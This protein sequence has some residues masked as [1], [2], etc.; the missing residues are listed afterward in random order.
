ME[1]LRRRGAQDSLEVSVEAKH[2][3]SRLQIPISLLD[4]AFMYRAAAL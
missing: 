1:Q 4:S 2:T 3:S